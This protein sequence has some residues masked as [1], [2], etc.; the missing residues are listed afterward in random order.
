MKT[1]TL[2]LALSLSTIF[3]ACGS[4]SPGSSP[5]GKKPAD[6]TLV[7]P[8]DT[9]AEYGVPYAAVKVCNWEIF[10]Y[11]DTRPEYHDDVI[12][13]INARNKNNTISD[14][15]IVEE[16]TNRLI[17]RS[18][19]VPDKSYSDSVWLEMTKQTLI[20]TQVLSSDRSRMD[21]CENRELYLRDAALK[22]KQ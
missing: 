15:G 13:F 7:P 3:A 16:M 12:G 2:F 6:D 5:D 18:K 17:F 21:D 8:S 9:P 4:E 20:K 1:A 14:I 11:N 10:F 19:L 22:D